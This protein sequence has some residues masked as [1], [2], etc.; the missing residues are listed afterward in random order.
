MA[1]IMH[2]PTLSLKSKALMRRHR[3]ESCYRIFACWPCNHGGQN[4]G[5]YGSGDVPRICGNCLARENKQGENNG[6]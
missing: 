4:I 1:R 3:C 2:P 6:R 5:R